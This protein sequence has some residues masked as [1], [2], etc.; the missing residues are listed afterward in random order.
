MPIKTGKAS[1]ELELFP[2]YVVC[3]MDSSEQNM[4]FIA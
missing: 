1:A 4:A 2:G 3:R